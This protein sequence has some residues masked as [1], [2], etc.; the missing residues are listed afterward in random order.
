MEGQKAPE[1]CGAPRAR[2]AVEQGHI[3]HGSFA[4]LTTGINSDDLD[5][6]WIGQLHGGHH[7]VSICISIVLST[8]AKMQRTGTT[9]FS[10]DAGELYRGL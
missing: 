4:S 7:F 2:Y 6:K 1:S 3:S 9:R 10:G 8:H 5:F